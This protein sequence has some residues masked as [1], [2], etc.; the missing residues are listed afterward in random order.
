E[1]LYCIDLRVDRDFAVLDAVEHLDD[2]ADR[3]PA[4]QDG[5]AVTVARVLQADGEGQL[6]LAAQERD[7]PHLLEVEP[8]RIVSAAARVLGFRLVMAGVGVRFAF[9]VVV[10]GFSS[11]PLWRHVLGLRV[12]AV[13]RR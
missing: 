12:W 8:E 5:T 7:R 2:A 13:C 1:A 4:E 11:S 9:V 10:R 3:P 6:L